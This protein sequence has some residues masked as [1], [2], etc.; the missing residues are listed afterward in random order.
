MISVF[1]VTDAGE[2]VVCRLSERNAKLTQE[3]MGRD[4]VS[5]QVTVDEVLPV[6]EMDYIR[7]DG[8]VYTLNRMTDY[9]EVSDVEFRY[10][11]IF[12]GAIYNLMDKMYVDRERD[13]DRFSLTGTLQEFTGLLVANINSVDA[14]WSAGDVPETE[15]K[16]LTFESVS[17]R[18]V[19]NRLA[20][21]FGVEY[22]LKGRQICFADRFENRTSLVFERGRG[23]GL[24]KLTCKNADSG[25]T[26][27]R[28]RVYGSTEN[29]PA[30]YRN[31]QADR[32]LLPLAEG[33]PV[34]YLEDFSEFRKVVERTVHFEDVKPMFKGE[35]ATVAGDFNRRVACPAIDF[36]LNA[37]AVGTNARVNF[38]TGELTG[39]AFEFEWDA[40]KK[41]L[42]LIRQEDRMAL[43]DTD[44]K[45]P[46]IPN[47]DKQVKAGDE[48]NFTGI[49]LPQAYVDRAEQELLAKGQEWL[50]FYKQL[51]VNFGL[52]VDYRFLR[53]SGYA[54]HVGDVVTVKVPKL[55]MEKM[56]RVLSVEKDLDRGRL[57]C[58]VSN[59]LTESWEKKIE[60][61]IQAT[62]SSV[63]RVNLGVSYLVEATREWVAQH[64][65]RL[66][67]G[68]RLVGNQEVDGDV[69][70]AAGR[71]LG[72]GDAVLRVAKG[73][74]RTVLSVTGKAGEDVEVEAAGVKAKQVIAEEVSSPD[75]VSGFLG[76]GARLKD[77]RLE[78]DELTVRKRMNVHEL[79][80]EK[81]KSVGGTLI[82]SVGAAKV[83]TV[84][85]M[86]DCF[87][88]VY[89]DAGEGIG[90]P[91]VTDDQV[92]CQT[93]GGDRIKRYWRRVVATGEGYFDLS[94][95]DCEAGS[96]VPETGDEVVQLGHRSD[97]S[98]QSAIL[99][100]AVGADAPYTDHYDGIDGFTLAGK[101]VSRQGKLTGIV[102]ESF[103]QLSGAGMYARNVFLRGSLALSSGKTVD[104]TIGD[105]EAKAVAAQSTATIAKS[106][107]Q[108]AK[109]TAQTAQ[110]SAESA[111]AAANTAK[112][113]AESAQGH[114]QTAKSTAE[115]AKT[116]AESA[117]TTANTAKTTAESA[118]AEASKANIELKKVTKDI[119]VLM[120]AQNGFNVR[121]TE[122][123]EKAEAAVLEAERKSLGQSW[124]GGK[125]LY[126]DPAFRTGRNS[127]FLYNNAQ[128]GTVTVS[129][130]ARL[131]DSPV[132]DSGYNI[133]IKN[134]GVAAPG[135][136]GFYFG[137]QGRTNAVLVA[138]F[139][140]KIPVGYSVC[141]ATN[142]LGNGSSSF[143]AT[144]NIGTG[145]WEE[146]IYVVKCGSSG[147][148]SSTMY[149]Y[150]EGAFGTPGVPVVWYLA[151]ASVFDVSLSVNTAILAK[152]AADAATGKL[153]EWASDSKISPA[154]KTGLKQQLSDIK[155]EYEDLA[156]KAQRY[157][158]KSS[159]EWIAYNNGYGAAVAALNKYTVVS[160]ECIGVEADFANIQAY[161]AKRQAFMN[162]F[163]A[164]SSENGLI[165]VIDTTTLD[166]NKYYPVVFTLYIEGR[167]KINVRTNLGRSGI[168][169]WATHVNGFSCEASW[170]ANGSG[171][172]TTLIDRYID[173]FIYRWANVLP[174]GSINQMSNSSNEYIYVRG[175]G[176]YY[177][178]ATNVSAISL[179]TSAFTVTEQTIGIIDAVEAPEPNLNVVK[180]QLETKIT[181]AEGKI[182][183]VASKEEFDQLGGSNTMMSQLTVAY[184]GIKLLAK[185]GDVGTGIVIDPKRI[186]V[187]GETVFRD[188][189]NN[190]SF[191]V[192]GSGGY[193]LN[194]NNAFKVTTAGKLYATGVEISGRITASDGQFTGKL[195]SNSSGN[196]IIIDPDSK[197]FKM[198]SSSNAI[199]CQISFY[200]GGAEMSM[201]STDFSGN[202]NVMTLRSSYFKLGYSSY[203]CE[204]GATSSTIRTLDFKID[205][206]SH[207]GQSST[208]K[209]YIKG[210]PG[211]RYSGE[212]DN[213]YYL[214]VHRDTG[215]IVYIP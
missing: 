184:D 102:D 34:P 136:G 148:V 27:T 68:N 31:G 42:N 59:Y 199:P 86:P 1:R 30:G 131:A 89:E 197:S 22:Y 78:L 182:N 178:R 92:L 132:T 76:S 105:V 194:L 72:I 213:F 200:E 174:I 99:L 155:A 192:F 15:R 146:Y 183:L 47:G 73:V 126:T 14:G 160:P 127:V 21:E 158:L 114:A 13:C 58:N 49:S 149:F 82:V 64:F 205:L 173:S 40:T 145:K 195:T 4:E 57:S 153:S 101:L 3:C 39:V 100:C 71:K 26:V 6:R 12:E 91:F 161:Y 165:T 2:A 81:V 88:C 50:S 121:V 159:T 152:E 124:M 181:A 129:R 118:V 52:E 75:F 128:N 137:T 79:M 176:I 198:I 94:R 202:S 65:A 19:L 16:N 191:R 211:H 214:G 93:F 66:A 109:S 53:E 162:V 180:T 17:C 104:S 103:G 38:L 189:A 97:R 119:E 70:L 120:D 169:Q 117:K 208:P 80:I 62:Q 56:L 90:N 204:F 142:P 48:F 33:K 84:T 163:E 154:E 85:D 123:Q 110:T 41:E 139:I 69:E 74:F 83:R 9:D 36:D 96:A 209:F 28:V 177:V 138:R 44:G 166:Q 63:E 116:S 46:L 187:S 108:T 172:G 168:P 141:F 170:S 37:V 23:K 61:Q 201:R 24:Y 95:T 206:S 156:V 179:K 212:T 143:F 107:A 54:L 190:Q 193:A 203:Y 7:V 134:I 18:E 112:T 151:Y 167:A 55:G 77:S 164:S 171:W 106:D 29:L 115:A 51:R 111:K 130:V 144:S 11:L 60:G 135:L 5:V 215:R 210:L 122:V 87:R 147:T 8:A 45:R 133:E 113:T 98:R 125:M 67:G 188:S 140:A 25:N 207:P 185:N 35:V 32:L 175:G 20:S 186:E 43:P 157:G 10:N 196:R 150:L